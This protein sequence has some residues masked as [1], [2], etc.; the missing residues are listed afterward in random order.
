MTVTD[1]VL[2]GFLLLSLL[3]GWRQGTINVVGRVGAI[4]LAYAAARR[5]SASLAL[6]VVERLPSLAGGSGESSEQL[7]AFLSLFINT[8]SIVNRLVEILLFIV[9]F[10]VVCWLVRQVAYAL[11]GIFGRGLLGSIN[12]SLGA[13]LAL[14]LA[15]LIVLI[16]ADIVFPAVANMGISEAPLAAMAD[17]QVL[18][19][20]IR[21]LQYL[22]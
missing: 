16:L 12:K 5:Y 18:M 15:L 6:Y 17:S 8:D 4:I 14:V 2:G 19:P 20:L 21:D 1:W 22:F 13:A 11:T 7:T 9:I 3:Y 10:V